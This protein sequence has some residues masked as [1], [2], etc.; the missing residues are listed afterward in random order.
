MGS[1]VRLFLLFGLLGFLVLLLFVF[2]L[3]DGLFLFLGLLLL[4][5]ALFLFVG[6]GNFLDLCRNFLRH[7]NLDAKGG[8]DLLDV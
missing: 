2:L 5:L 3:I 4:A 7:A 8:N 6:L 1:S